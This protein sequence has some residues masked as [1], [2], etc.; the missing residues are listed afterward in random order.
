MNSEKKYFQDVLKEWNLST[1]GGA[2][3][4]LRLVWG[5]SMDDVGKGREKLD[6]GEV[7]ADEGLAFTVH[8]CCEGFLVIIIGAN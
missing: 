1:D 3:K 8:H 7:G 2:V 5:D 4:G 6:K